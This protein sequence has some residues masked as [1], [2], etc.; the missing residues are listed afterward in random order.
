MPGTAAGRK[1]EA[2]AGGIAALRADG[3]IKS[4]VQLVSGSALR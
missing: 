1:A 2:A 4:F 3:Y